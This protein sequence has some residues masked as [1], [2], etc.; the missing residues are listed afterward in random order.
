MGYTATWR[1]LE[2]IIIELR[3]K[4][5]TIPPNI[6]TDLKSAKLMI[7]ISQAEGS[8]GEATQ[9]VEEYLANVEGYLITEA[10]KT[11]G[12]ERVDEWLRRLEAAICEVCE[13]KEEEDKF[14]LGV[15]RDQKWIRV[16]PIGNLTSERLQQIAKESNLS[17]SPQKDGRL[18]V[19]GQ[20]EDIKEF[21]KKMTAEA[22]KK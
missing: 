11:F 16:E 20:P 21:L 19:Y 13:V 14:I 18:V 10:E 8:T 17:V 4:G 9:K 3:K 12:S 1:I 15:P 5:V 22:I 2:D 6:M 7:N